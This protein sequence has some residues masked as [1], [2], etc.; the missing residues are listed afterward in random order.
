MEVNILAF[1]A[2]TLFILV[3]TAFLLIIYVKTGC[4]FKET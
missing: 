1:I 4:C 2:T 3:P